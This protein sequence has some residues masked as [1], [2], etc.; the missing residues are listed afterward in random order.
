MIFELINLEND[1]FLQEVVECVKY[2]VTSSRKK[3]CK[4][5]LRTLRLT[6]SIQSCWASCE[7]PRPH[8]VC[9][10]D[11]VHK[12]TKTSLPRDHKI[13]PS[14]AD[15]QSFDEFYM[16]HVKPLVKAM[17]GKLLRPSTESQGKLRTRTKEKPFGFSN[18]WSSMHP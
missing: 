6:A 18:F 10:A 9:L 15:L 17:S 3:S 12:F 7:V 11:F 16:Q 8:L 5:W 13:L 2:A 1:F 4:M 14:P